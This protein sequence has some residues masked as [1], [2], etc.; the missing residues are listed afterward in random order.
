MTTYEGTIPGYTAYASS[1]DAT[2]R[3]EG[4]AMHDAL[5]GIG[6]V[7]TADTGQVDWLT[8]IKQAA[9]G[10]LIGYEIWRF[11]DAL[12][13]TAPIFF[14]VEYY[15]GMSATTQ[16]W[17]LRLYVGTGSD[18]AGTITGHVTE[19]TA[20]S[21][22]CGAGTA[23]VSAA[24]K[25]LAS[26]GDGSMCAFFPFVAVGATLHTPAFLIDRSRNATGNPTSAG[27]TVARNNA[28][29]SLA[30]QTTNQYYNYLSGASFGGG[31]MESIIPVIVP[32]KINGTAVG[33]SASL[34]TAA[35]APVFPWTV[36]A[37][38]EAPWQA[39]AGVSYMDYPGG[40]FTARIAGAERTYRAIPLTAQHS[41]W[42]MAAYIQGTNPVYSNPSV[43]VAV[44]WQ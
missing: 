22:T 17:S 16:G 13:A 12:Q 38:G 11:N 18:G 3:A 10:T 23:G 31:V 42:G 44:L 30:N 21:T 36:F 27:V 33:A 9:V 7:K 25:V 43:G 19:A 24:G 15:G 34:A 35:L 32:G 5:A 1:T 6:M 41:A 37:P 8:A 20:A 40:T 26:S 29:A 2:V 14:R 28:N 4:K 39:I